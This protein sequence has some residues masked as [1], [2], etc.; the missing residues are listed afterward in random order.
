M[1]LSLDSI[2]TEHSGHKITLGFSEHLWQMQRCL[3]GNS[4]TALALSRQRKQSFSFIVSRLSR[5]SSV[6]ELSRLLSTRASVYK[7]F[8][9]VHLSLKPSYL[10]II[11]TNLSFKRS[12]LLIKKVQFSTRSELSIFAF[13]Y[14]PKSHINNIIL[15]TRFNYSKIIKTFYL[16]TILLEYF[17]NQPKFYFYSRNLPLNPPLKQS[18]TTSLSSPIS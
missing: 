5:V 9:F 16:T 18:L 4:T 2:S 3:N 15:H 17:R 10:C 1:T 13:T 8:R 11:C 6:V 14:S 7:P 12:N